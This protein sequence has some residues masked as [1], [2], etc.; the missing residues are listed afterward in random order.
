MSPMNLLE[1]FSQSFKPSPTTTTTPTPKSPP[2]SS[3]PMQSNRKLNVKIMVPS[4]FF[5]SLASKR[6][7]YFYEN[8]TA[9]QKTKVAVINTFANSLQEF[10]ESIN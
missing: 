4:D 5:S 2:P 8:L 1:S 10:L 9:K 3:P 6:K 7:V